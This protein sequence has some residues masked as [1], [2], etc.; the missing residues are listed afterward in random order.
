MMTKKQKSGQVASISG[1]YAVV[2][3]RGG[4]TGAEVTVVKSKPLPPTP[5]S[6][7]GFVLVDKT[8]H[9]SGK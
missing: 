4:K 3:P 6:G 1:Q 9:K 5:K 8:K 7:Q 2:G